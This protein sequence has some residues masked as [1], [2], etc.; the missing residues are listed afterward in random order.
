[1]ECKEVSRGAKMEEELDEPLSY[2]EIEELVTVSAWHLK[3]E[4]GAT[5]PR[6]DSLPK[7]GSGRTECSALSIRLPLGSLFYPCCGDDVDHALASF[8]NSVK[9]F[10]FAD[11]YCPP[12]GGLPALNHTAL[13]IPHIIAVVQGSPNCKQIKRRACRVHVHGKDG[14]LT[15]IDDIEEL[16]VFYYRGDSYGEGGSN[17][18]WLEPVLFHTVLARMLDGGLIV[19]D[20]SNCGSGH[21]ERSVLWNALCGGGPDETG[22]QYAGRRFVC[23]GLMEERRGRPVRAWQVSAD[24]DLFQE[25]GTA[26]S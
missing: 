10:H 23:V 15:L 1:M 3:R 9:D 26:W 12:L 17:Q 4:T 22:F 24:S 8:E 2:A 20:G 11:P 25:H 7:Q 18:R 13:E 14:L 6:L 16:S 19:T 5:L 21:A